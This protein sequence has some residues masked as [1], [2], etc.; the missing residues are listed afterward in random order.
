VLADGAQLPFPAATFDSVLCTQVLEHVPEPITV[1]REIARVLRPGGVALVTVPLNSGVHMAPNDFLRFTEFALRHLA[2][3]AG[4]EVTLLEERGGR[5]ASAA[6]ALL[7]V[8][9]ED[10]M[11]RRRIW[12]AA[13]RQ[14]IRFFCYAVERAG[15]VLD[16]R[17]PKAGSPLGYVLLASKPR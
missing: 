3:G 6:Q 10:R 8:F 5:I 16:R 17:F 9:E 14:F 12:A 1:L 7:L 2:A 15:L 13:A 4:L 11:P